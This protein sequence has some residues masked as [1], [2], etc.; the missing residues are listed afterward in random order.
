MSRPVR[1][2][3]LWTLRK[4][5]TWIRIDTF[6]LLW[7]FCFR[8]NYSIPLSPWDRMCHPGSVCTDCAGWSGSI[9]YAEAIMLVF[10]WNGSNNDDPRF[11]IRVLLHIRTVKIQMILYIHVRT[12]IFVLTCIY[13]HRCIYWYRLEVVVVEWSASVREVTGLIPYTLKLY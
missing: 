5:S 10:S 1:K 6:R 11:A 13:N 7:I 12:S 2:P 9:H 8:N 4:V 3:T